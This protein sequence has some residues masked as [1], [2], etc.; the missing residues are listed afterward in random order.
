M[1]YEI[2][3]GKSICIG[4]NEDGTYKLLSG[5]QVVEDKDV[6]ADKIQGFIK[7]GNMI[8]IKEEKKS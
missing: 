2:P 4:F 3:A 6:P 8:S 5:P 1:K 7:N